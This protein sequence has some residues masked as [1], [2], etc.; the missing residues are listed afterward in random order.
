MGTLARY[1][2]AD[3]GFPMSGFATALTVNARRVLAFD[4]SSD[5]AVYFSDIA[6]QNISGTPTAIVTYMMASATTGAVRFQA[7]IEAVSDGD[8]TDLDATT[9]F[10][11][12]NSAGATVPGTA[13]YIDQLSITL[14]NADSLAAG[15]YFRLRL[16]RDANGTS[17]TDDATGDCY[18]LGVELRDG[19]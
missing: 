13:G 7:A 5:E 10:D 1:S 15:D 6:P 14:T 12:D 18:V 3:A 9:S 17:G 8:A 4:A 2:A 11:T 19:S 16:N